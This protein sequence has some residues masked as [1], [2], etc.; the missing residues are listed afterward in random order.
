[1][2]LLKQDT[3]YFLGFYLYNH[4][5]GWQGRVALGYMVG[6]LVNRSQTHF[7]KP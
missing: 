4:F 3:K 2:I 6:K 7:S 1:M 5:F